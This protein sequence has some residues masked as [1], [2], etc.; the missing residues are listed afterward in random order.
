[1]Q[2]KKRLRNEY[3]SYFFLFMSSLSFFCCSEKVCLTF[4]LLFSSYANKPGLSKFP[5]AKD[6]S[7]RNYRKQD[8]CGIDIVLNWKKEVQ[9]SCFSTP[10]AF[11]LLYGETDDVQLNYP[12]KHVDYRKWLLEVSGYY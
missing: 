6:I 12:F 3:H 2:F 1:M 8:K 7:A 4:V 5:F 11:P 9:S 10:V